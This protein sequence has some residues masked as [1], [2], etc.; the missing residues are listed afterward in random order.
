MD[1]GARG[2][3]LNSVDVRSYSDITHDRAMESNS[4]Q[5]CDII[6][7]QAVED[8]IKEAITQTGLF[9]S[10]K[11]CALRTFDVEMPVIMRHMDNK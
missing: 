8:K 6:A 9:G 1:N 4:R 3:T 11:T 5:L 7:S 2:A 10:E